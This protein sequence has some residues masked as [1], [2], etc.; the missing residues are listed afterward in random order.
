MMFFFC[1]PTG[2]EE[3]IGVTECQMVPVLGDGKSEV[4]IRSKVRVSNLF[5]Y[6]YMRE[7][8]KSR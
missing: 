3:K 5:T 7:H 2:V 6:S 4:G 8:S 1:F